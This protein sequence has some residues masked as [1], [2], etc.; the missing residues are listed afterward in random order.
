ML[1]KI[2][3][4][5]TVCRNDILHGATFLNTVIFKD[6][7]CDSPVQRVQNRMNY[8]FLVK[9]KKAKQTNKRPMEAKGRG[10]YTDPT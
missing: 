2:I 9:K 6:I 5:A 10:G 4:V 3:I 7:L 1:I 8:F